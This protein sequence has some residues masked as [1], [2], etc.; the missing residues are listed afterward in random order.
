[1]AY[2]ADI[3]AFSPDGK[4]AL[5]VEVKSK[6]KAD[7]AWAA[8]MRRNLAAHGGMPEAKFFL[9]AM[10]DHFYLWKDRVA[11]PAEVEPA[12]DIDPTYILR[13]YFER[14]GLSPGS[15]S[16]D[17]FEFLVYGWLGNLLQS[18]DLP[19]ELAENEGWILESGLFDELKGAR[20]A[21][22]VHA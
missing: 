19:K 5:V 3:V 8:K 17:A 10:P 21:C 14:T 7:A 4:P 18:E 9:L 11:D 1:M 15:V 16:R 22:E 2:L 20:L 12:Y 13:P 6:V